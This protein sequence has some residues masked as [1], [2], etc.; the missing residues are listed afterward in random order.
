MVS[1]L[2]EKDQGTKMINGV[3]KQDPKRKPICDP[4]SKIWVSKV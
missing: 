4:K 1:E 3:E 2:E